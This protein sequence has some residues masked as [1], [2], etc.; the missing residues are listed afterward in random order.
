MPGNQLTLLA[1]PET[2]VNSAEPAAAAKPVIVLDTLRPYQREAVDAVFREFESHRGTL[3]VMFTGS[4]K[5]RTCG[6]VVDRWLK[7]RKTRVLWLAMRDFLLDDA[8]ARLEDMT[9]KYVSLEKAHDHADNS[10]IVVGSVQTLK[11]ARLGAWAKDHF[12][13]I[14]FDEAHHAV[15]PSARAI[16]D[17]FDGAKI[18]GPTATPRRLDKIGMWNVFGSEAYN[19]GI[20]WGIREGFFCP[21][22][23]KARMI[24]SIDL[25]A[26]KTVAGD[27]N[28]GQLEAEIAKSAA[29]IAQLA[30]EEMEDRPSIVYTPGIASA[31]AVTDTLNHMRPGCAVYVDADTPREERRY[32]LREFGKSHQWIVNCQIYTEGLDVPNARGIVIARPTKSQGLYIQMAGR[33]GRPEGWIGQLPSKDERVAAI[34]ASGKP[35]FKLLDV[36]GKPGR[37]SLVMAVEALSG[38]SAD[39]P[40][41][42]RANQIIQRNKGDMTLD[43]AMTTAARELAEEEEID[44]K[45]VAAVAAAAKVKARHAAF[46][47]FRRFAIDPPAEGMPPGWAE[48]PATPEQ[49]VW[50]QQNKLNTKNVSFGTAAALQAQAK[51]WRMNGM[52]SF[53]QRNALSRLGY[54]VDVTFVQAGRLM[55]AQSA[56]GSFS[57]R[58]TPQAISRCMQRTP[59]EEG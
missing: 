4:G 18:L 10:P 21:V 19:R 42:K 49:V 25:S 24:D 28:L 27:L 38:K 50:M 17:H 46:D 30:A 47:P 54:P 39:S 7:E 2:A 5:T 35:N 33:G 32:A 9:G 22:V 23:P 31:R 3:L 43:E 26:V 6:A 34:A 29:A 48:R 20:D 16:F 56:L 59:G 15:S 13:L 37:H 14:V 12:G 45:R 53:R 52:A 36:T 41:V 1:S 44:R 40:E 57:A 11:G 58:L 51:K 55:T 8:R